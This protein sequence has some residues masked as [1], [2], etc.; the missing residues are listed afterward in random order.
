MGKIEHFEDIVAWQR[1]RELVRE[2]YQVTSQGNFSK[3]YGLKEQIRRASVSIISNIAEGFERGGDK[4]FTQYLSQAKGSC[5]EVRT[6]L[7]VAWDLG[8]LSD[9]VFK[10][11]REKAVSTGEIISGLMRYLKGSTLKGAKFR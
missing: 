10:G 8:Y 11:L 5:G 4:E 1:G 3:D 7:Y 2:V 6:Q 9:E